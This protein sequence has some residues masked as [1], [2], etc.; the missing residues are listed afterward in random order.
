M[1]RKLVGNVA[2]FDPGAVTGFACFYEAELINAGVTKSLDGI[3]VEVAEV[4]EVALIEKP[5]IYPTN[6]KGD[7]NDLITLAIRAGEIGGLFLTERWAPV[8]YIRPQQWKGQTPK[9]I[10]H[11]R[12]LNKLTMAEIQRLPKIPKSKA[13]NMLDAVGIGLWWLEKEGIRT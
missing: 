12:T 7:P 2:A 4:A 6:S 10:N 9:T 13:H 1:G 8:Q 5:V 3:E 11:K